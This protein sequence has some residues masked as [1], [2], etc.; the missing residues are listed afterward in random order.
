MLWLGTTL[1]AFA[2]ILNSIKELNLIISPIR[3]DGQMGLDYS[4]IFGDLTTGT[5]GQRDW[6]LQ[7]QTQRQTRDGA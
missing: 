5:M 4:D 2:H 3:L 6:C 7:L 1:P